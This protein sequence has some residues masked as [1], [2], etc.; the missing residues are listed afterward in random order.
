MSTL[1]SR[2]IQGSYLGL[3]VGLVIILFNATYIPQEP[4]PQEPIPTEP[5]VC[6]VKLHSGP[7]A[8]HTYKG[9]VK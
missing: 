2:L 3:W 6:I 5:V 8:T 1:N 4:I 7:I 9:V